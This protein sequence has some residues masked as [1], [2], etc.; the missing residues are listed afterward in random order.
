MYKYDVVV[1]GGGLAGL[2]A[3]NFLAREG[4]KIVV[5]EKSNRLGG[6]A[7]TNNKNGVL[8]NLG[9]HG[10]YIE[11]EAMKTLTDLGISLSGENA[12][13]AVQIHGIWKNEVYLIPTDISSIMSSSLLT[14]KAKIILS[15]LMLKLMKINIDSIPEGS[16][17]DW[18]ESEISDPMVRHIFYSLC[19]L[20][21][22]TSAPTLQL[23]KPVLKQVKRSLK[24]GVLYVDEGWE[25]IIQ[26][27]KKQAIEV[28]VEI[29]SSKNVIEIEHHDQSQSIRCSDGDLFNVP[30]CIVATPPKEALKMIKGADYTSL[31][32]WNEQAIPVTASCLDLGVKKLPNPNHQFAIGLDQSLFFTNQSRAA[33]LSEDGTLVVSLVKYHNPMDQ[34][35]NPNAE[36][37][38]L[39]SAM[40]LLHPDWRKEVVAQQFLPKITVVHDF[41]HVKR[42]ENPGPAIPQMKGIYIA[43][44]WCG[45][46]E[47]LADAAVASGKRAGLQILKTNDLILAKEG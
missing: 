38:Q 8:M 7:M 45:H 25:T 28:G 5:L 44:D 33:K 37:N 22:Y 9:A 20:T 47:L 23:A 41:P 39:E 2:T 10:L 30:E 34:T 17:A 24:G 27:L 12:S 6:R 11:G 36:K 31:R 29:I 13:K 42:K 32:T 15:K 3:A 18:A 40:D 19:R 21:T 16:L 46:E 43:G 14:W 1:I 26:K 35:I 4:K